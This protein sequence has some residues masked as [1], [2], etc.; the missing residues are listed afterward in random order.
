M[1]KSP[2]RGPWT[3]RFLVHV[4]TILFGLLS[5]WFLGFVLGDISTWPGPDYAALQEQMLDPVLSAESQ[6]LQEEAELVKRDVET[7]QARQRILRDST[8]NAQKT[9]QQLLEFQRLSLQKDV[10][11]SPEEQAALAES[12]QRFLANQKQYQELTEEIS[13]LQEQLRNL[14]SQQRINQQKFHTAS[15]PVRQEYERQSRQHELKLAFLQLA[16]LV[17]LLIVAVLL[18]YRQRESLYV[19]L[20]TAFAIAVV[21]KVMLV[22]HQYFPARYFKYI[23]VITFLVIVTRVLI[24]LL[25]MIRFPKP[26]WLHKQYREAYEAFLC[27]IC[28]YPIRRGP[29]TFLYWTRRTI[30]KLRPQ[31]SGDA[32]AEDPYT[33]PACG[34]NLFE[35]CPQCGKTRH[36]LLPTC[37][38]CGNTRPVEGNHH[39]TGAASS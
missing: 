20:V 18:F 22:M 2:P 30:K 35:A 26:D 31:P 11:P 27:P 6:R 1:V 36:S 13:R 33:C 19:P 28:D 21:V 38:S 16:V 15:E 10:K 23:L 7:Q 24:G 32:A 3:Q 5:Y 37:E 12:Q 29:L 39:W 17:P 34:T 9:M 25:R 4:F 14:E 8:D